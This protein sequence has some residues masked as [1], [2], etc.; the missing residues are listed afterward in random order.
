MNYNLHPIS[1]LNASSNDRMGDLEIDLDIDGISSTSPTTSHSANDSPHSSFTSQSTANSPLDTDKRLQKDAGLPDLGFYPEKEEQRKPKKTYKKIKDE[2]LKGPFRCHWKDC[3][4]VYETPELLY[5]HLCDDHVGRKASNNLSLTCFWDNCGTTTVKRDHI[6]SHLRVHVPLKPFHCDICPKSFKRPQDLKKHT[7][8]HEE[9][10]Q[11]KLKKSQKKLRDEMQRRPDFDNGA[12]MAQHPHPGHLPHPGALGDFYPPLGDDRK[13]KFDN[14]HHNMYVV[15]S[16]LNDFNFY[17]G[18]GGAKKS[19][20]EPQYNVD[21]FSKL[22]HLDEQ[23]YHHPQHAAAP[24]PVY[25]YPH[26]NTN[27]YEAEKFFNSLSAS[28]DA[29]YQGMNP[30]Y[31]HPHPHHQAQNLYP[32]V[33]SYPSATTKPGESVLVNNHNVGYSPSYPQVSRYMGTANHNSFP[34]FGV[35]NFQKAGQALDDEDPADLLGKLSLNEKKDVISDAESVKRHKEMI[36]MVCEYLSSLRA[37]EEKSEREELV[38]RKLYP[39]IVAF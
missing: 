24:P 36:A 39:T 11:R 4:V 35:S 6:T 33:P 10:H 3:T 19:K 12:L 27:L 9:D 29:Q 25:N 17:S 31:P 38:S 28:I 37:Q 1:Y 18:D 5:D 30:S 16:I 20:I 8:I 32:S 13:R 2:D 14:S 26:G 7:K 15:N 21:M 34:E 22:N 23:I